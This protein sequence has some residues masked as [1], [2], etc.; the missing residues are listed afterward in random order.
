MDPIDLS[1]IIERRYRQ[2]L[3][4]TFYFK[5]KSFRESFEK[6]LQSGHLSK[7]PFLEATPL[8]KKGQ[9]PNDLFK[10]LLKDDIEESFLNALLADR[11]LYLHQE[12]AIEKA[13]DNRNIII[14]TGTGSGKT[15]S[16]LYP[17]LLHLYKEFKSNNLDKGV[18]ALILYPMNAL[19]NDQRERLGE[20]CKRLKD[21]NSSF[22]FT[23]GQYIGET[24]ENENDASRNAYDY[25]SS[26]LP[27]ELVFRSEMR[28]S[29]PNILLTNYSMLEYLLLRPM[30][31]PL[32][33]NGM[34]K[35]WK[36][37]VL[38]EVHQYKGSN[39]IEMA[40]LLR[41]LKLRLRE[42]GCSNSIQCIATSA[43]LIDSSNNKY[44]VS[45]FAS[46]LFGEEFREDDVIIGE[47]EQIDEQANIIDFSLNDYLLL[48]KYIED[49]NYIRNHEL[50]NLAKFAGLTPDNLPK[51]PSKL[52]G[53]LL[54]RDKRSTLLR[55]YLSI[56][57]YSVRDIA[58]LIFS[59]YDEENGYLALKTLVSLLHRAR[60]PKSGSPLLTAR[61]HFFLRSLEGAYITYLPHKKVY[62]DK[63]SISDN[64][65]AFEVALC[66]ECGQH[67]LVA[68]KNFNGDKIREAIRDP[69]NVDFGVTF[70]RPLENEDFSSNDSEEQQNDNS[71]ILI[72][73]VKCGKAF[74]H[75]PYCGHNSYIKV[76]KEE[77]PI[78]EDKAD[79]LAK[80]G[81]CGY[82]ASGHNPVKTVVHGTDGPNSVIATT[83]FQ[84]LPEGRKKILAFADGRQEAAFFA[85]YLEESYK[86]I[87][88]RNIILKIAKSFDPLS[89]DGIS[90]STLADAAF[91]NFRKAFKN[92]EADD[93]IEIR[94]NIS[95]AIYRE[96]LTDEQRISLSGVGL[97]NWFIQ[98]PEWYKIPDFLLIP[99]W[100]LNEIEAK[101]LLFLLLDTMRTDKAIE[102]PIISNIPFSW[103]D[104]NLQA[105]QMT[106]RIGEPRGDKRIR[107]WDG[108]RNK[109]TRFLAKLLRK[110]NNNF[111]EN[112]A[113]DEAIK[114]LR[115]IWDCFKK[116]EEDAPSTNDRLL[117]QVN[118]GFRLN[119]KW[120][121]VSLISNNQILFKCDICGHIYSSNIL[122]LCPKNQ[123]NG[124]LFEIKSHEINTNHY[125][126]LYNEDLPLSMRVEE[127]SAQ[128]EK[129]TARR[130]QHDFK[131]GK[132]NILSC[133]T[134]FELGVDLGDLDTVFLRNIPPESF[135][136][137]QRVGRSGRRSEYP[138]FAI[139]FCRR[140]PHD[141]FH[142]SDPTRMIKGNIRPPTIKICN[143]K[144]LIR[145]ITAVAL[146]YFFRANQG[147]FKSVKDFFIDLNNPSAAVDFNDFLQSNK[148]AI[149]NSLYSIVPDD[150]LTQIGLKNGSWI[151]KIAGEY[152]DNDHFNYTSRLILSE[153]EISSDYKAILNLEESSRKAR[154]YKTAE[155]AKKRL[156]TIE[157][158]DV[159]SFLSR[160]AIIP[161]YGFPT[162]V[163]E[164]DTHRILQNSE[165]FK[166]SLQRDLSIAISEFAPTNKI[167]ANKKEWISYGIKKVPERELP[168]KYYKRCREHN[169]FIEWSPGQNEPESP[170]GHDITIKGKYII[171]SFGFLTNR[172][173]LPKQPKGRSAKALTTRPYFAGILGNE[174]EEILLPSYNPLLKIK[175]ASP[176]LM[177]ILCEGLMGRG[178]YI[179]ENCGAGFSKL[180]NNHKSPY[181]QNCNGRLMQIALGHEFVTDVLQL[182]FV[183]PKPSDSDSIW[184]A[185]SL[186]YA[187]V[188]GAAE[189]LEIPSSD[190]NTTVA[191]G[192]LDTI[193]PIILYD[194]VPGGAG[195]VSQLENEELIK[196][197]I[198][199]AYNRV[200]GKCGCDEDTSCYGCLRNYRNQFAHPNLQRGPIKVYLE[201]LL[202]E[203]D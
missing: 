177:A 136:Y 64:A 158:E 46:D 44:Q 187:L 18:R 15:E 131:Q 77:S 6:A 26:R 162:D 186:A 41:R 154:N 179:C 153:E 189:V 56:K 102:L 37:I 68:Q 16:F 190:L 178:F 12:R 148:I 38:D 72:L 54:L 69:N 114:A 30:D 8:F 130:F 94:K 181:G 159:L 113:I 13:H 95:I 35:W 199:A 23:F 2:Y 31:S 184:F 143:E 128:L 27:G 118:D 51:E 161:K 173:L 160:K 145:H 101:N 165:S 43:T 89:I 111:N 29:P 121:R 194:N 33:D 97:I 73:C 193:P 203:W 200:S 65:I 103:E 172:E 132:I 149:E 155:W 87:L 34:A 36:F 106:F 196:T 28:N 11:H 4:T 127:H 98:W 7:G 195:L 20:I 1:S 119:P 70:L 52:I 53:E 82:T 71:K 134:T 9:K 122:G 40:M 166:I 188:E 135:N 164:L 139:T 57:P 75:E 176:G 157:S 110:Y 147:R 24:P 138:G 79:Q 47:T 129:D 83:L 116:Y 63:K 32:F 67:Y 191:Y 85:W 201:K 137:T 174:R 140:S 126:I 90:L 59:D 109:R 93:E 104:L 58:N 61:Y 62:L 99:P 170:C 175:K 151:K 124:S 45:Q 182:I 123:C 169:V 60:N 49:E 133:S 198:K 197:C 120:Y 81:A 92:K 163:V 48:S 76:I 55:E 66:K 100:S 25:N 117:L 21:Y 183:Y 86:E 42:G 192:S 125:R 115:N 91:A 78:E 152:T 3:Q 142:F 150:M 39:G 141:I 19:A 22:H 156:L 105:P 96:L 17:I 171:P 146:S 88:Y 202:N 185:Y 74:K 168:I 107:S 144:I 10:R 50:E 14:A 84:F 112:E 180:I 5:D 80:C 108:K 167:I